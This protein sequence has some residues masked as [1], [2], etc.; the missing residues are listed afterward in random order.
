LIACPPNYGAVKV[1][2]LP[3]KAPMGVLLVATI[4]TSLPTVVDAL[5]AYFMILI[6]EKIDTNI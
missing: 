4:K 3:M 1:E 2:S 5:K 6:G